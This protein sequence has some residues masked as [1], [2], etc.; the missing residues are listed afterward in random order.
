MVSGNSAVA[1]FTVGWKIV[2]KAFV[3]PIGLD[4]VILTV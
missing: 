4:T 2:N 3:L 1:I